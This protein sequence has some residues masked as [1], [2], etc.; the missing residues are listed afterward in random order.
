MGPNTISLNSVKALK[1]SICVTAKRSYALSSFRGGSSSS[2]KASFVKK[3]PVK[4]PALFKTMTKPTGVSNSNTNSA[5]LST[6]TTTNI[7]SI[8]QSQSSETHP[9]PPAR[10]SSPGT[11]APKFSTKTFNDVFNHTLNDTPPFTPPSSGGLLNTEGESLHHHPQIDWTSSFHGIGTTQL[12]QRQIDILLQP[13]DPED[14][15]MKPDGLIYLPEIKYRRI[16]NKS[17]GPG[18]WGLIPR[19]D[20]VI[21]PKLITREY[22][23]VVMGRLISVAR[24]EQDYFNQEGIPTATE[25]C[26]SNAL[27]RCCKDLGIGSELWDPRFIRKFKNQYCEEKFVT[28]V[29]TGKKKR[30]WKRKDDSIGYPY[31]L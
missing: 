29:V 12:S 30:I 27:M 18:A 28:H 26:K 1:S 11:A 25:G 6:S 4:G 14:I 15:E 9:Q 5:P 13:L 22:G 10:A 21:T 20:T 24:G 17:L 8:S 16:L 7:T 2:T 31:K 19:S 23:L 3:S